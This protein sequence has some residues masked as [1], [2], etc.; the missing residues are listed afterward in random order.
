MIYPALEN[1]LKTLP[2]AAIEEVA[3]YIDYV[4]YKFT[5]P[6]KQNHTESKKKGFGCLREIPCKMSPDF[7]EPLEEFEEY[8]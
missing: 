5:T 7:D 2:Q 8:M 6:E 1:K 3:T 4:F